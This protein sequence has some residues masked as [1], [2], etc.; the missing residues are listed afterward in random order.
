MPSNTTYSAAIMLPGGFSGRL[1]LEVG[2]H[3]M[4][5]QWVTAGW[6]L[7]NLGKTESDKASPRAAIPGFRRATAEWVVETFLFARLRF[8]TARWATHSENVR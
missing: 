8:R 7:S 3:G 1:D 2:P 5:I 6:P 4:G